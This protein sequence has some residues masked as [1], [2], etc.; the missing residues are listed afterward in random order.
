MIR[1]VNAFGAFMEDENKKKRKANK[2]HALRNLH[3][4]KTNLSL[5]LSI[6]SFNLCAFFFCSYARLIYSFQ[7]FSD[8]FFL[9]Y[10]SICFT[11]LCLLVQRSYV[12]VRFFRVSFILLSPL[13]YLHFN[14]FAKQNVRLNFSSCCDF[15]YCFCTVSFSDYSRIKIGRKKIRKI[16]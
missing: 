10:L 11:L 14:W 2:I 16:S 9:F 15:I 6:H 4:T 8:F 7:K 12:F 3:N 5:I 13:H 1:R